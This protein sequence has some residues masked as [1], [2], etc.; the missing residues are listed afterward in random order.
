M[1]E[2]SIRRALAA[3]AFPSNDETTWASVK[4]ML[5]YFLYAQWESGGLA[6]AKPAEA[7]KV[8]IRLG[9]TMTNEDLQ[10]GYMRLSVF[11]AAT[12]PV[13]FIIISVAQEMQGIET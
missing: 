8:V 1:L 12:H 10:N 5:G 11:A 3:Y 13:K 4:N 7:F 9:T 2:Q 6:G